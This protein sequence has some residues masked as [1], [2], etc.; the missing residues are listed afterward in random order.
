[1][2]EFAFTVEYESG[3]DRL[4]DSFIEYPELAA[5][6]V[7]CSVTPQSIWRVDRLTGPAEAIDAIEAPYL[8]PERC[9]EC[10]HDGCCHV[11]QEYEVLAAEST[12]E[13]IYV[14]QT[15]IEDCH[16]IPY[17]AAKHLGDGLLYEALR[18]GDHH[19]WRVL[20]REDSA[21]GELYDAL[22]SG[23]RD[24]LTLSL[25]HLGEPTHWC[26]EAVCAADLSYEQRHALEAAVAHGYYETP[27][28]MSAEELA[29]ELEI[30]RSTLQ[31]R[32][33]RAESWLAR[34]FVTERL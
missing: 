22:Q 23:L 9:D 12:S 3:A 11:S 6:T 26:D 18:R 5:K 31:Y 1:M 32:L 25:R 7:T 15:D 28:E 34:G 16:S 8:D 29:T 14:Y 13:T 20:M 21:V 24:G 30:P 27:R 19:E 10:L 33:R 2:R 4:M 17:L